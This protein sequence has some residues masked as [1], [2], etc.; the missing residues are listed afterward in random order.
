MA[1]DQ[2]FENYRK[3]TRRDDFLKTME[4]IDPWAAL[5]DVIE[6]HYSKAGRWSPTLR[7]VRLGLSI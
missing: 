4:A 6:P 2:T 7:V 1:S 5:C 3:T